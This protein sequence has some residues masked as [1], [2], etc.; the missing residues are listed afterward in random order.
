MKRAWWPEA[1]PFVGPAAI[2]VIY[3][4]VRFA[5]ITVA[6]G[7]GVLSPSGNVD[8]AV[9]ALALATFVLR[10]LALFVVPMTVIYRLVM[11]VSRRWTAPTSR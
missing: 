2:V 1:K 4:I 6:A 10:F 5:F 11:R 7:Q 9:A 3:A 8:S